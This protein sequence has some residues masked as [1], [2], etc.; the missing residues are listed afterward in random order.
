M[1]PEL[2]GMSEDKPDVFSFPLVASHTEH[3]EGRSRS[4]GSAHMKLQMVLGLKPLPKSLGF[5]LLCC[6]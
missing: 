2:E 4:L 6:P 5:S 3:S 1:E